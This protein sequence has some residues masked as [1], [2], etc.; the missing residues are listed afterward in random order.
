MFK[1]FG[2]EHLT[3]EQVEALTSLDNQALLLNPKTEEGTPVELNEVEK[4]FAKNYLMAILL[5]YEE[6]N[7]GIK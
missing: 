5:T 2:F 4:V 1:A 6:L 7:R 3:E